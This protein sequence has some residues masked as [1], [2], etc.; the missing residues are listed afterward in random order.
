MWGGGTQAELGGEGHEGAANCALH[1]PTG[2][3]RSAERS[4]TVRLKVPG[5]KGTT[6]FVTRCLASGNFQTMRLRGF[7]AAA[8]SWKE[9]RARSSGRRVVFFLYQLSVVV[10]DRRH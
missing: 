7:R 5:G 6:S 2:R 8:A 9:K 3:I 1:L 4:R 10:A